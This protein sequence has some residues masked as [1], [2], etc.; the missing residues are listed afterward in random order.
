MFELSLDKS[1]SSLV[2][3]LSG[4]CRLKFCHTWGSLDAE[5]SVNDCNHFGNKLAVN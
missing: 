5:Q 3:G 4:V 2:Y 1:S